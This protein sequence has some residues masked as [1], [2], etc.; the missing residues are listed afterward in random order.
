MCGKLLSGMLEKICLVCWQGGVIL[1]W[2]EV[3]WGDLCRFPGRLNDYLGYWQS[4]IELLVV[5]CVRLW[6]GGRL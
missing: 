2:L 1:L 4:R 3:G 5:W 6:R